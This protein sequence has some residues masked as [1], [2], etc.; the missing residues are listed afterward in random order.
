VHWFQAGVNEHG[1]GE[2]V[3]IHLPDGVQLTRVTDRSLDEM[4]CAGELDAVFSAHVPASFL[5]GDPRIRR[6][7]PDYEKV[8]RSYAERTG[9]FPIM[10]V[11]AIRAAVLEA[12]PWIAMNL[13]EAFE[14]SKRR[15][16]DRLHTMTI[17]A[18]PIPWI[19]AL[20]ESA[21][22]MFPGGWW[23]Y[24]LDDNRNTLQAFVAF[25]HEQGVIQKP[26]EIESL[27]AQET[28]AHYR[29]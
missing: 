25:A 2:K 27:F 19:S 29:V 10:H 24:G 23:P 6:L 14:E 8:E 9:I 5:R 12:N 22:G 1:R 4:L 21:A 28:L 17:S 15:W 7:F 13:F 3:E 16:L 20:L 11:V 18:T 26:I